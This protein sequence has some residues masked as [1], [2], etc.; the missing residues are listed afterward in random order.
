MDLAKLRAR[1]GL[2]HEQ[3]AAELGIAYSTWYSY[4]TGRRL[5]K[6]AKAWE[7]IDLARSGGIRMRLEDVYPRD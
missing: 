3:M 1:L 6:P 2:T 7:I 5:P 4:E